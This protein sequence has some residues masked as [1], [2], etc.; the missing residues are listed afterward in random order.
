MSNYLALLSFAVLGFA[1]EMHLV[2]VNV[3]IGA[4]VLTVITRYLAYLR[5]D[6]ALSTWPGTC[7]GSWS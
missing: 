6:R 1:L 2:F 7:L 3:I 4:T 5:R